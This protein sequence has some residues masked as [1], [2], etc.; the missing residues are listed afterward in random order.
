MTTATGI[1]TGTLQHVDPT[2]LLLMRNI[3]DGKP[4]RDLVESVKAVG[5][6]EP[7]TA[8][9]NDDGALVVRFGHR[10]VLAAVEAGLDTVPVYVAGH[11]DADDDAEV[12]RII[13]QRDEN[14]HRASLTAGEEVQAFAQLAAFGLEAGAI[15][16]RARVPRRSVDDA[17]TVAGSKV[18][19][20]AAEKYEALTLDQAL[21]V[22]EFEDDTDT[23]KTLVVAAVETPDQF[24]HVA[25][26]ARDARA[27]RVQ[28]AELEAE[29]AAAGVTVIDRPEPNNTKTL[30]LDRLVD[31]KRRELKP[32][33]HASC[34]GH[35]AW[36]S[37]TWVWVDKDGNPT[38]T[39]G[40]TRRVERA[41]ATYGCQGWKRH[42]HIDR[43]ASPSGARTPAA[44]LSEAEREKAKAERALVVANNKAWSSAEAVR[45]A[46][47][48]EFATLK[49]APAGSAG[50]LAETLL[51][52]R[53][54]VSSYRVP[55]MLADL[56]GVDRTKASAA[57]LLTGG[58]GRALVVAVATVAA[59]YEAEIMTKDAWRGDGT[60]NAVGRY[61]RFL[62]SAGYGLSD[63]EKY[64]ISGKT[65]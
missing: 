28:Q 39:R 31:T 24:A 42:G 60:T 23:V 1:E 59:C 50:F 43:W 65:V 38:E 53:V 13:T 9:V 48:R 2:A 21:T 61:L 5:V 35:V 63:V 64:A 22:A 37:Q 52:D 6:L 40:S 19:A 62:E 11:D 45:R 46:W 33:A 7:I 14:T 10:R 27:L 51:T 16:K 26:A 56:L 36:I 44:Q 8:R 17:L 41:E 57:K 15:A 30:R 29:L 47:V 18:A 49:K 3:R 25:Q 58:E 55:D 20:R 4:T 32:A 12:E 54:V 34:P